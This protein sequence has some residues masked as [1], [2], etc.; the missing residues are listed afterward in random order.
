MTKADESELFDY[1]SRQPKLREWINDRHAAEIL[2]LTQ[3]L[4]IDQLRRAQG[5]AGLLQMILGLMD[6]ASANKR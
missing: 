3:A 4:D 2:V 6:A 1:L 5:R